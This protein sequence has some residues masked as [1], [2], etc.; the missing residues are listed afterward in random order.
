MSKLSDLTSSFSAKTAKVSA[1][2]ASIHGDISIYSTELKQPTVR[3]IAAVV[4]VL[5]FV[6][7]AVV[8]R[9]V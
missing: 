8:S 6:V 4:A 7:G 2:L 3:R 1:A 9:L 5:S